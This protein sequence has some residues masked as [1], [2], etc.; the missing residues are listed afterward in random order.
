MEVRLAMRK[1]SFLLITAIVSL[2]ATPNI[3]AQSEVPTQITTQ[4][5]TGDLPFSTTVGTSIEH[6]DVATGALNVEIPLWSV[7]GR[8]T[9]HHLAFLW[10]SNQFYDATRFNGTGQ[11]YPIWTIQANSGWRSNHGSIVSHHIDLSCPDP[12]QSP[13]R[14]GWITGFIYIDEHA[15]QHPFAVQ[16]QTQQSDACSSP[17]VSPGGDLTARGMSLALSSGV[18]LADGTALSGMSGGSTWGGGGYEDSNGNQWSEATDTLG[19][20]FYTINDYPNQ[21]VLTVHDPNGTARSITINWTRLT[22]NTAFNANDE[23]A[24]GVVIRELVGGATTVISSIVLPNNQTY[25]FH[26]NDC[27]QQG[28]CYGEITEIDLPDGGTINYTWAT[29]NNEQYTRRY[30]TSRTEHVGANAPVWFFNIS[31]QAMGTQLISSQ[32]TYPGASGAYSAVFESNY[33]AVTDAQIYSGTSTS[34]T[35]L[36][37]YSIVYA[38]DDDPNWDSLCYTYDIPPDEMPTNMRPTRI[39]T[40]LEDGRTATKKDLDYERFQYTFYPHHCADPSSKTPVTYWG[41]RGN[42]TAMREYDW[43]TAVGTKGNYTDINNPSAYLLRTTTRTYLHNDPTLG[44]AYTAANIVN[45]V[46]SETLTDNLSNATHQTLY[47]YDS[48]SITSTGNSAASHDASHNSSFT[49]RGNVSKVKKW[50]SGSTYLTTVYG[51]DDLGNIRS[52]TDPNQHTTTYSYADS[53]VDSVFPPMGETEKAYVTHVTNALSQATQLSYYSCSGA[54]ESRKDQNDINA[55]RVGT[56]YAYDLMGRSVTVAYS[57]GGLVTSSY[58]D[59]APT[60]ATTSTLVTSGLSIVNTTVNDGLGR[61]SLLEGSD[62]DCS[63]GWHYTSL[64]YDPVASQSLAAKSN[65][66]CSNQTPVYTTFHYDALSRLASTTETD[67]SVTSTAY[68]LNTAT[69]T[70]EAG[71]ARKTQTDGLG[72]L[73]SVSEDP[74]GLN[75]QSVYKYDAFNN[76]TCVEQHGGQSSTGCSANPSQDATSTW[77]V[78]RFTYD[79]LSHLTSAKNPENGTTSYVY[80]AASNLINKTAAS[81][82]TYTPDALNRIIQKSYSD[83]ETTIHYCYDNQQTACGS[84]TLQV[85]NGI[86]RRTAMLDGSGNSAWSYDAMGRTLVN[87]KT[88]AGDV[89][90]IE[91]GYNLDGSPSMVIDP[92]GDLIAYSY[93]SAGRVISAQYDDF[94]MGFNFFENA[95][96][97][98]SGALATYQNDSGATVINS[99]NNRLQPVTLS[100][101][102]SQQPIFSLMYNFN[103]GSGDNGNVAGITNNLTAS[104]SQTFTY[105]SLNRLQTAGSSSTWGDSYGYDAWGNLLSKT[106][107]RG[108]AETWSGPVFTNNQLTAYG[109]DG[110]GNLTSVNGVLYNTFSAENQLLHQ[111]SYNISYLYDGDGRRVQ[112]SGGASGTRIYWYDESGNVIMESMQGGSGFLNEY[113]YVGGQRVARVAN[114][115]PIYY[116]YGDHLGT[117]R[118]ITDGGGTK[119]YDA[120]Y[121]PWGEEQQIYVN[122][123][124]QNYK[125]T[126]KER[127]PDTGSDYFGARWYKGTMARF[128]SPDPVGIMKQKLIDPQQWNMYTYVRNNPL[129]FIDPFGMYTCDGTKAF[130]ARVKAAYGQTQ[131]AAAAAEKGSDQQKQ[132]NKVLTFLGKPGEANNVSIKPGS[133]SAGELGKADT[134]TST[135]LLGNR[136]TSTQIT[137]DFNQA[138]TTAKLNRRTPLWG[139]EPQDDAGV[140]GHEGT[141]GVDQFP[142]WRNPETRTQEHA[143]E[144]NAYRNLSYIYGELGFKSMLDAGL[145][146]DTEAQRNQAIS[147]GA[148]RSTAAWCEEG[149]GCD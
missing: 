46:L 50:L 142:L 22:I 40:V 14:V 25:T 141:H 67:N 115:G 12:P 38:S 45:K 108:S 126:G 51:Y 93:S 3:A 113:L 32:V 143:T 56:T 85:S 49:I 89:G 54:K 109:Y 53:F 86:G 35:P 65:P 43:S 136:H 71:K 98:P 97:T 17:D 95:T 10:N 81:T 92:D 42:V 28:H 133:L 76:L 106:V 7:P 148:D 18:K 27:D 20:T 94:G 33:G 83:G 61:A 68:S 144:M 101:A 57:D 121:F 145:S 103:Q 114:L 77:R 149:G 64:Q 116:Y 75:Y 91:Y 110:A 87:S 147:A 31:S 21:T 9:T 139:T 123:C 2:L 80:D 73:S 130:C 37:E 24:G 39:I 119:C 26:Y 125:F 84:P 105:D 124:P 129:R 82:I 41:T 111:S 117:A 104:R 78:R 99:Y 118:L 107:T 23:I 60:S 100:A 74:N 34:G 90:Y 140:L 132:Q 59:S 102:V 6:V 29:E 47:E 135:D 63:S 30:V 69:V 4:N 58:N 66:Y 15:S 13:T 112:S 131:K 72:R 127:D 19:R 88:I 48:T 122:T 134:S 137:L 146:A 62:P 52:I 120:D 8:G 70:D 36:R 138:D 79:P 128:Y 96:Y 44:P 16:Q 5:M 1:A 55:G 11:P